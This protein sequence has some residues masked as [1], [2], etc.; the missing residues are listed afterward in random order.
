[1]DTVT[2][3]LKDNYPWIAGIIT[4]IWYMVIKV[5]KM[6]FK[7]YVTKEELAC[8]KNELLLRLDMIDDKIE[9]ASETNTQR[10]LD[11]LI[12]QK[13]GQV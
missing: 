11:A 10:I 8:C 2:D 1:M 9:R 7:D 5:K 4:A 13:H 6:I 3:Y 12:Q